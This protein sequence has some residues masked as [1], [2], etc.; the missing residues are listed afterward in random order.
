MADQATKSIRRIVRGLKDD[1]D[2]L[3][4]AD[5]YK[6][7]GTSRGEAFINA[8]GDVTGS[9]ST[10]SGDNKDERP[11]SST[12]D[13]GNPDDNDTG[14]GGGV[15]SGSDPG[16]SLGGDVFDVDGSLTTDSQLGTLTGTDPTTAN[17]TSLN[18]NTLEGIEYVPPDTWDDPDEGPLPDGWTLGFFWIAAAFANTRSPDPLT[19]AELDL[20]R[21]QSAVPGSTLFGVT[22]NS[23]TSYTARYLRPSF[24]DLFVGSTRFPCTTEGFCATDEDADRDQ[25]WPTDGVCQVVYD[26]S[27]GGY[28]GNVKDPDCSAAQQSPT[29]FVI[30]K[31]VSDPSKFFRYTKLA[32]GGT[33]ITQVD[34]G[35]VPVPGTITK[36][37]D[38]GGRVDGFFDVSL[39]AGIT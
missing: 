24:S 30:I 36:T 32:N 35:G 7:L 33:K 13:T 4:L 12:P 16:G 11:S 8:R 9:R 22:K 18:L 28:K 27:E 14:G 21:V 10:G 26:T 34:A 17:F 20:P 31:S 6:G 39:D 37:T 15:N 2:G 38:E 29:D 5:D 3:G 1:P 25:V 19:T 23:E